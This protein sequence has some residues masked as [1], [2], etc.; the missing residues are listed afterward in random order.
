MAKNLFEQLLNKA[1][2]IWSGPKTYNSHSIYIEESNNLSGVA[3]YLAKQE[4]PTKTNE[5]GSDAPLSGVEK[6]L[7]RQKTASPAVATEVPTTG[8][9]KYLARQA[10]GG[11]SSAIKEPVV[12]PK[13]GV[14][15]YLAGVPLAT[16]TKSTPETKKAQQAKPDMS[17]ST[18]PAKKKS[19]PAKIKAATPTIKSSEPAS[20][21]VAATKAAPA[22]DI[23]RFEN[24][25]QCQARTVK[26]TQCKN[27]SNLA[28]LQQTINHQKYQFSACQQHNN[29]SFKPYAPLLVDH[30]S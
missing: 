14:A 7:A 3:K 28:G 17:K 18:A 15:K 27:T 9:G 6:Y 2:E 21:Q 30:K 11:S 13:T 19:A 16:E 5:A 1:G 8:V 12:I 20:T 25:T 29:D 23:I 22:S 10:A 24:V 26:G 4:Q